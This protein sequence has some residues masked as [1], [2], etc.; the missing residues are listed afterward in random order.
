MSGGYFN[1]VRNDIE[2]L[3]PTSAKRILDVGAGAGV[4]LN[5]LKSRYPG[6]YTI[7]IEGNG[8]LSDELRQS[9]DEVHIADL[10]GPLPSIGA[11][12]LV[13][14]LDVLEHLLHPREVL[15]ALTRNLSPNATVIV[16]LPNVAHLNVSIPLF[17]QG[18]FEYRDAGILDRT[19]LR[20]F[21][22]KSAVELLNSAN[23]SV[24]AGCRSGLSPRRWKYLDRLTLGLARDHL[25]NQYVMAASRVRPPVSQR[26]IVW[27]LSDRDAKQVAVVA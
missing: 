21:T 9:V 10:N 4:T 20:F 24:K 17:F 3:L 1:F 5:W 18:K 13:L 25:T 11:P 6:A 26:P 27:R 7:A 15:E 22:R 8:E 14:F 19:H 16:S 23:L 12:D 2:A